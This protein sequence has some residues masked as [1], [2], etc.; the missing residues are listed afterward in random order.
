M[1]L[2][3][4]LNYSCL[5]PSYY[6]HELFSSFWSQISNSPRGRSSH[7][8]QQPKEA[9]SST[10]PQTS[11]QLLGTAAVTDLRAVSVC[12]TCNRQQCDWTSP[13][14]GHSESVQH[15]CSSSSHRAVPWRV[16][17]SAQIFRT[18]N[19]FKS[20]QFK[21]SSSSIHSHPHHMHT[22]ISLPGTPCSPPADTIPNP[23][24]RLSIRSC[25][26]NYKAFPPLERSLSPF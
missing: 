18:F 8:I 10:F 9:L 25:H 16:T 17:Q 13:P 15:S 20:T 5:H 3:P 1:S 19:N 24:L 21:S 2:A 12:A 7:K 11:G 22:S 6:N 14:A 4:P 23:M 26:S